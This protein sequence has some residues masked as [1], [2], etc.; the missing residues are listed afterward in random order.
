[1]RLETPSS[2]YA[3]RAKLRGFLTELRIQKTRDRKQFWPESLEGKQS[4]E[5]ERAES[6]QEVLCIGAFWVSTSHPN[7]G[8]E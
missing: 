1:M 7:Q 3:V 6:R 4:S 2:R 8:A 5:M